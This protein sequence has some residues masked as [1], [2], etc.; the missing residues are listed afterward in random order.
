MEISDSLL[1]MFNAEVEQRNGSY[2]VEIPEQEIDLGSVVNGEVY[3]IAVL[4]SKAP[5][6]ST[7]SSASSSTQVGI[8]QDQHREG[9]PVEAGDTELVEIEDIGEQGDGL[10]RIG[11]GYV[12]FVP[13]TD[14][15]DRVEVEITEARDNFAFA[16]VVGQ[17]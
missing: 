9:P 8:K 13:D 2:V 4:P 16:E 3:R 17:V 6:S 7:T 11:P 10:A 1:T 15:G 12:V 14:I 5:G